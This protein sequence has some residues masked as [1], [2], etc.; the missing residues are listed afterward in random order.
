L[1]AGKHVLIE[2]PMSLTKSGADEIEAAR[3]ASGKVVFVGYMRRYAEAFLRAKEMVKELPEGSIDYGKHL[4]L[5][6]N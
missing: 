6:P 4:P 3:Q 2:K 1:K 5:G